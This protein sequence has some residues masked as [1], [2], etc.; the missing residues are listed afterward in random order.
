MIGM[1][2]DANAAYI[3]YELA[4]SGSIAQYTFS[5]HKVELNHSCF[6]KYLSK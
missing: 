3:D 6:E 2:G 5:V 4:F 1:G